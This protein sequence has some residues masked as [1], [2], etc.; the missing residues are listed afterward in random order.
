[1]TSA[2]RRAAATR[3]P[4]RTS[5]A[6]T[7]DIDEALCRHLVR[8]DGQEDLCLATYRPSTG[9]R[10]RTALLGDVHL[11]GP[12][13][14]DVHGNATVTGDYVWRVAV[15][16]A[17]RGEGVA[18][19]HSHPGGRGWQQMSG[20]DY[21]AE[22]GYATLAREMTGLPLVGMT[23]AGRDRSWSARH[24]D[25]GA[26]GDVGVTGC[27]NVRVVG[28]HLRV[29]W[30]NAQVGPPPPAPSNI[31]SVA[32]WGAR[33]HADVARRSVLIVGLGSVGLDVAV[34]LAATGLTRIGLMDYDT[35]EAHNLDRL[36]GATA[37]DVWLR[38]SKI[39]VARRLVIDNATSPAITVDAWDLSVCEPQGWAAAR[40]F[41]E[42]VCAVDRPWP[43]A[44][45]NLLA[46]ADYIPVIDGGIAIDTFEDGTGMRNA[47]WRSHVLRPGRP[48][49][50]C[51]GQLDLGA[52]AADRCG[53]LDDPAY[54]AGA[55][56]GRGVGAEHQNT[57]AN[58]AVLS[59]SAV[60]SL[61]AQYV[62][63]NVAPGGLGE[64]GPLQ[65]LLS[66]H[67]LEHLDASSRPACPVEAES[68]RG[69][70][71]TRL[72]GPHRGADAERLRHDAAELGVSLRVMR[73]L[74]DARHRRRTRRI[75]RAQRRIDR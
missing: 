40:D 69:D 14:R 68:G 43:R 72:T 66:T 60:A 57:S 71:V 11:P 38:R 59:I 8:G 35:V 22:S 65:Y 7:A 48:C 26:A 74:D 52:V 23:L 25:H 70:D 10:R 18:I 50:S 31:R 41:D 42:I 24:W 49:M 64:P 1:M 12:G 3:M 30:D 21:D 33:R 5:V 37:I 61:L 63:L 9:S 2:D 27:E 4:L 47:T 54:I 55:H 6:M 15:A 19:V 20:L 13:E 75:R 16:A 32:S 29:F 39:E 44:V 45:L 17:A 67:T 46:Y 36:I 56:R 51:N 62:S 28:D 34:R 58:V 73:T 53:A